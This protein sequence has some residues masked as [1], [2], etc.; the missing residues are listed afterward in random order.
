MFQFSSLARE[1]GIKL[2]EFSKLNI[3]YWLYELFLL[4]EQYV[5]IGWFPLSVNDGANPSRH[6][7]K[8]FS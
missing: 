1:K 3:V 5:K 8:F 4:I 6:T 7:I 2:L